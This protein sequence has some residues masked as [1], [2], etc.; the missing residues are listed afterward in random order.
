MTDDLA[1]P[2]RLD[3]AAAP[4]EPTRWRPFAQ[5]LLAIPHLVILQALRGVAQAVAVVSWFWILVTGRLPAGLAAFQ[6]MYVRYWMRTAAYV[7]FLREAYPPFAFSTTT[8]DPGDDPDV[9][10][11]VSPR[12]EDRNRLTVFFRLVLVIPHAVILALLGLAV[13]LVLVVSAFAILFG[14]RWPEGLRAFVVGCARWWLRVEAYMLLLVDDYPPF[15]FDDLS[16]S[17]A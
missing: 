9:R 12:L 3:I 13:T 16:A 14:G 17:P 10:V 2:T 15:A 1:Y 8:E 4:A 7:G 11:D 6:A 5:W